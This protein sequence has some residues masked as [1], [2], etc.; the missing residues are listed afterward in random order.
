VDAFRP[1]LARNARPQYQQFGRG[2]VSIDLRGPEIQ[3]MFVPQ[4][5]LQLQGSRE[6]AYRAIAALTT[7]YNPLREFIAVVVQPESVFYYQLEYGE[8]K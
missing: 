8:E 1:L 7:T 3:M 5:S 2:A 6:P 4:P